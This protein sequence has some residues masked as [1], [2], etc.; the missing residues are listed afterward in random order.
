VLFFTGN[1][2]G[3][4]ADATILIDDKSV[5][6]FIPFESE[7]SITTKKIFT[8]NSR[9]KREGPTDLQYAE[10]HSMNARVYHPERQRVLELR[11]WFESLTTSG[12]WS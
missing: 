7:N 2:A 5:A 11:S 10:Q 1:R 12:S 6:H 8:L 3:V 9:E 4:T